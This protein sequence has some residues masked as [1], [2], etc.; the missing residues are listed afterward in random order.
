M[1]SFFRVCIYVCI[2]MVMF[3]VGWSFVRGLGVFAGEGMSSQGITDE[4]TNSLFTT[5]TGFNDGLIGMFTVA[6]AA[7]LGGSIL[8]G[9]LTGS[10]APIGV[11]LFGMLFWTSYNGSLSVIS[12]NS[13]LPGD[14]ILIVT[15]GMAMVFAAAVIGLLTGGG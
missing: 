13:W 5:F 10:A 4:G 6:T 7:G 12:M 1:N 11:Y 3:N 9:W 15:I 2:F 14:F 8:I